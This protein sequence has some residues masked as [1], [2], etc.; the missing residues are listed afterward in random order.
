M[1]DILNVGT[2]KSHRLAT[3]KDKAA[4][5]IYWS[6]DGRTLFA[7]YLQ[8]AWNFTWG[9]IGFLR[10]AGENIEPITRDTNMYQTLTLSADAKTLATVQE[11][12]YATISV[13]SK[14]GREFE[15]PRTLLTQAKQFNSL[16]ALLW[17]ADGNL[18]VGNPDRLLKLGTDGTSQIQLLVDSG[19]FIFQ[20]SSCGTSYSVLVWLHHRG[21]KTPN[22]WRVAAD[23]SPLKLTDGA[24]DE[25]PVCSH[26]QTWVYYIDTGGD[27]H[28]SRV[29]LDGSGRAEAIFAV[30][31]GYHLFPDQADWLDV[32]PDGNRLAIALSGGRGNVKIGVY[33]I[34]S[35]NPP[36][37]LDAS[38]FLGLGLQFTSDGKS[39]ASAIR[40]NGMDK[41]WVA[42]LDGSAGYPITTSK[43]EQIWSF[44]FSSDGKSLAVLNGHYDSDVVLLQESKP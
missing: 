33:D 4:V 34:G 15:A 18:I 38:N 28:I 23:G 41:I 37:M 2:G 14:V 42:P 7:K 26:D 31:Q 6:P 44:R 39:V 5:E 12:S 19:E 17:N 9:Q 22:I 8:S 13:L 36:R 20:P 10:G 30:P 29:P 21:T 11:R 25:S 27:G 16:S 40:E 43:S 1:I 3:F 32:S 35:S 24:W